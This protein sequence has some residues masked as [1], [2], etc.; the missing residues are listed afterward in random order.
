[1]RRDAVEVKPLEVYAEFSNFGVV[2]MP[3]RNYPGCV[4][5]GDSLW[6]LW[7]TAR[8]IANAVGNNFTDD[9]DLLEAVEELHNALLDR[10]LHYQE[11]IRGEGFDLLYVRPVTAEDVVRLL[12]PG[13]DG[14]EPDGQAEVAR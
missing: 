3:G 1:L 8:Q 7:R 11:V 4:I 6:T 12:P 5:Q 14:D 2:R 9:E 13:E 10:L